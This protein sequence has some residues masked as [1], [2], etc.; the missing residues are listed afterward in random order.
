MEGITQRPQLRLIQASGA[1]TPALEE[2]PARHQAARASPPRIRLV[3]PDQ[4]DEAG[5]ISLTEP[6]GAAR[7]VRQSQAQ[8]AA[9]I[10]YDGFAGLD[11]GDPD[12]ATY[13][14]A[15]AHGIADHGE[16]FAIWAQL[17]AGTERLERFEAA[18]LG[19]SP[20]RD[21]WHEQL[22]DALGVTAQLGAIR[23]DLQPFIQVDLVA[24]AER[25]RQGGT[26]VTADGDEGRYAYLADQTL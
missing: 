17:V 7:A 16:A 1:G 3:E 26:V 22:A 21:L 19:C 24:W 25:L 23:P 5:W 4:A 18:Y 13:L 6:G 11:P 2:A 15:L 9:V 14:A 10:E 20:N 12:D 8:P